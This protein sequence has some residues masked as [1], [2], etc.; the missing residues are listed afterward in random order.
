MHHWGLSLET[1]QIY[2]L[3]VFLAASAAG[4]FVGGPLGDRFGRKKVIW[5]SIVGVLPFTLPLC[6]TS[7]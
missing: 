3:F 7:V 1:A 6:R 4:L 2:L 5:G